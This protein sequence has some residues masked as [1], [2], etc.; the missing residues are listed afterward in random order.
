MLLYVVERNEFANLESSVFSP[1][2]RLSRFALLYLLMKILLPFALQ[3]FTSGVDLRSHD[4]GYP[5][6]PSSMLNVE[7]SC[8]FG[9]SG[10]HSRWLVLSM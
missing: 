1:N 10:P 9:S 4:A 8:G 3:I 5:F 6:A 7:I 2:V